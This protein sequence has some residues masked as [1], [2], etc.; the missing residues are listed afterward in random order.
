[1]RTQVQRGVYLLIVLTLLSERPQ[2]LPATENERM[3]AGKMAKTKNETTGVSDFDFLVGS[4]RVRH[5]RLKERLA[6]SHDWIEFEGTCVVQKI[7]DG[8]GNMDENFLDFPGGA[9][10][11]VTVR[12]YDAARKQWSIW[13]FDGRNP[14]ISIRRWSADS[15]TVWEPFTLRILSEGNRFAFAFCGR[16]LPPSRIGSGP[17]PKTEA[18]RGKLI[19]LWN[20]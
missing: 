15:K 10:N 3:D 12:T 13:W 14:V 5:R 7:L 1:M 8:A 16:I 6:G 17:S 9:Y 18:K 20:S 2:K 19:G 11:A 4:W